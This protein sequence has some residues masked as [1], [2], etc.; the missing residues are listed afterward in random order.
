[1][2]Q[3]NF[4][5][6]LP[7]EECAFKGGVPA[8]AGN[9]AFCVIPAE[10]YYAVLPRNPP[11]VCEGNPCDPISGRKT[12]SVVD[13]SDATGGLRF[14]RTFTSA[15][16]LDG[17]DELTH[18]WRHTYQSRMLTDQ[19]ATQIGFIPELSGPTEP[20]PELACQN[21]APGP[22]VDL[23]ALQGAVPVYANGK[24]VATNTHGES[25]TI[26]IRR[27]GPFELTTPSTVEIRS[28][29]TSSGYSYTFEQS[30]GGWAESNGGDV[31][32]VEDNGEWLFR[33]TNNTLDRFDADGVLIERTLLGGETLAIA[34]NQEGRIASVTSNR[35]RQLSFGYRGAQLET[36]TT[37]DGVIQYD[38][39]PDKLNLE[40]VT[41]VDGTTTIYHYE[42]TSYPRYLTG[43]TNE[44]G[45]RYATWAYDAL[46]RA[47]LSEHAGGVDRTTILYT[48]NGV[49]G[50]SQVT[51]PLGD[52]RT[53]TV[54]LEAGGPKIVSVTGD[55]C[56]D[57]GMS[58]YTA[59]SYDSNGNMSL[60]TDWLGN[61]TD[62]THNTRGLEESRTEALGTRVE[63]T[64]T[65]N[66][67][68]NLRLPTLI[69]TDVTKLD[70]T[71]DAVGNV[72][73]SILSE[74]DG[75]DARTTSYIYDPQTSLMDSSN[76][77]RTDLADI[78]S[79][80]YGPNG[81]LRLVTD[82][83]GWQTRYEQ[84]N[85]SG[86]PRDVIDPNGV[87]TVLGYDA[88]NRINSITQAKDTPLEGTTIIEYDAAGNLK[89]IVE[90]DNARTS[91]EYDGANRLEVIEDHYGDRL[92]LDPDDAGN[93]LLREVYE[94]PEAPATQGMLVETQSR[95]YDQLGL[96]DKII[97]AAG[98][99]DDY[100]YDQNDNPEFHTDGRGNVTQTFFDELDR[101][102]RVVN[103][104]GG[105]TRVSY[106]SEDRVTRVVD[107]RGA[108]TDYEH[109]VLGMTLEIDS[110]DAGQTSMEYDPAGNMKRHIDGR[111]IE[112]IYQYD[113]INRLESVTYPGDP[114][115]N[116]SFTYDDQSTD[117]Q[118]TPNYGVGRL[119]GY[120]NNAGS[121]S[122][123]Y[124]PLGNVISETQ[125]KAG[126][127]F[128]TTYVYD[129]Q[130]QLDSITYPSGRIVNYLYDLVGRVIYVGTKANATAPEVPV[131]Q[132]A[133]YRAFGGVSLISY[134]SG[135][136]ADYIYDLD[137]RLDRI[138][139][140]NSGSSTL[141]SVQYGYDA[142][143]N[144][145]S[146]TDLIDP[147]RTQSF[148]YDVV[149]RLDSDGDGS[150]SCSIEYDL[151]GNRELLTR[152][153]TDTSGESSAL[154]YVPNSNRL[155][156]REDL[157]WPIGGS[158][159]PTPKV[160]P[161]NVYTYNQANRMDSL[162][163]DGV[164]KA[165]YQYN[166]IGQRV[167]ADRDNDL[168]IHYGPS[169]E[170]LG[171]TVMSLGGLSVESE[172]DYIYMS[173]MPIAQ[174]RK[175]GASEVITYLHAD[176]LG[177]PRV[178]T[179]ASGTVVWRWHSDGFGATQPDQD[180]DGN[181]VDTVVNLRFPGQLASEESQLYYNYFRD[182][183]P[184]TG[185][186]IQ[187]DP[188][189]LV[190]GIN[191]Y[192]YVRG[193]PTNLNDPSGL[194]PWCVAGA[195]IGG[196]LSAY[197]QYQANGG[198]NNF[199]WGS[200]I[201]STASG[202]LGG[203]LGTAASRVTWRAAGS[204]WQLGTAAQIAVNGIGNAA[205]GAGV[206]ATQNKLTGS[207]N[208]VSQA[209]LTGLVAGGFGAGVG[210]AASSGISALNRLY[211]NS[212]PLST[213]L[214]LG[215]NAISGVSRP[216]LIP[217]VATIS[218]AASNTI[219]NLPIYQTSAN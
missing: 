87:K 16:N 212:L 152:T 97:G 146:I 171:E 165:N 50:T 134:G 163:T 161:A 129:N 137:G 166:A 52:V 59:L 65:T 60:G 140:V 5:N 17:A 185:R 195:L 114:S 6:V 211:Y 123:R 49:A 194:C 109:D 24:C 151:N 113:A 92:E 48:P 9:T 156:E 69:T 202:A 102:K 33:D 4:Q 93:V 36:L 40:T 133:E 132:L 2:N 95:F 158:G 186:Y 197:S 19:Q 1:M 75:S 214:L 94:A 106:N 160:T 99:I 157:E 149:N 10:R 206:T 118:G 62:Y 32:L 74:P 110:P 164:L 41:Q 198:F 169:G 120:S 90:P 84:H 103:A 80:D 210:A 39:S 172:V 179:D 7:P 173:G 203:G 96:L 128:T 176:H 23:G 70:L 174:V 57:C 13:Y 162:T 117:S 63:R 178:G 35:G 180:P 61:V 25:I 125:T 72:E 119:T 27:A 85:P 189:G 86:F 30:S 188:I 44:L 12:E 79:Y 121:T 201:A 208:S 143:N 219:S 217:G 14:A 3:G 145:S 207:C 142:A 148:G 204:Q 38:Y 82:A 184:S 209:A 26:P 193:N 108:T 199:N 139:V 66:W 64:I 45:I 116:V 47:S 73:T 130:S 100:D 213:R 8:T 147:S 191:T 78:T 192:S 31:S 20:T 105:W 175:Q 138:D 55:K 76:G 200:F 168:Y 159:S 150:G 115:E 181:S 182:Y 34:Y 91:F 22:A 216:V 51:G 43:V 89:A 71:Y 136:D 18:Y 126:Q 67:H 154:S 111:G 141:H 124:D 68:P 183:D 28:V 21:W 144:V 196:G 112:S 77:P 155:L 122:L 127:T 53:Y 177:T 167:Y 98:Q 29:F 11:E 42:D 37:P 101:L 135:V 107:P 205:I 131:V 218:N 187:S 215:S 153:N 190:G 58:D 170:Y 81:D 54:E 83:L 56:A 15:A 88:R 46:G 104:D